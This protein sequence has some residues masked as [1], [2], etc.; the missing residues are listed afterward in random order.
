ELGTQN[1]Q[2]VLV[3]LAIIAGS[4]A[5]GPAVWPVSRRG[6][7]GHRVE[8]VGLV[9]VV[10]ALLACCLGFH[11]ILIAN[12]AAN[13]TE[14]WLI[15]GAGVPAYLL[16]FPAVWPRTWSRSAPDGL[17]T[18]IAKLVGAPLLAA[19]LVALTWY[20]ALHLPR[21]SWQTVAMGRRLPQCEV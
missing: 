8:R 14:R 18:L 4:V 19:G 7:P 2:R 5:L 9:M 1:S 3:V 20:L 15:A 16:I 21:V 12:L 10:A 13:P 17:A 11:L 6:W